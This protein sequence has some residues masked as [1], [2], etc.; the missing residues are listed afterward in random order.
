MVAGPA[1]CRAEVRTPS[2]GPHSSWIRGVRGQQW[3]DSVGRAP[4]PQAQMLHVYSPPELG[5]SVGEQ[6]TP[7]AGCGWREDSLSI[8]A[9][10]TPGPSPAAPHVS[11]LGGLTPN[12]CWLW[13]AP[14]LLPGIVFL[15]RK[16][17]SEVRPEKKQALYQTIYEIHFSPPAGAT[18]SPPSAYNFSK[19]GSMAGAAP[20]PKRTPRKRD[21]KR[22]PPQG[23]AA[24]HLLQ[25]PV[26]W[27]GR[28]TLPSQSPSLGSRQRPPP[29]AQGRGEGSSHHSHGFPGALPTRGDR[30]AV[31]SE[32]TCPEFE[33]QAAETRDRRWR[34]GPHHPKGEGSCR[35]G[36]PWGAVPSPPLPL[37]LVPGRGEA[38]QEDVYT[39]ARTHTNGAS[40][41]CFLSPHTSFLTKDQEGSPQPGPSGDLLPHRD[42]TRPR[43]SHSGQSP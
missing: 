32:V 31:C 42:L 25:R 26:G 39:H 28:G 35:G 14:P 6:G 1:D 22:P 12:F 29:V 10:H 33:K 18:A 19:G 34:T 5:G 2:P 4:V 41:T 8:M 20:T 36:A 21:R 17:S 3:Q 11:L 15:H 40:L 7:R 37:W 9:P 16:Q 38:S 30:S 24:P 13:P 43:A 23:L 27:G